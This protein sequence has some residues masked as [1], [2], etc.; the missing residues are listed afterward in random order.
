MIFIV[1]VAFCLLLGAL[2]QMS[3]VYFSGVDSSVI[4][5]TNLHPQHLRWL[6]FL[7]QL[8]TFLL[9]ALIFAWMVF[10]KRMW[11]FWGFQHTVQPGW[12]L[13]SVLM[14]FLLLPIIQYSYQLNQVIPLPEWMTAL[15]N[16][17]NN[18]LEAIL[19][20]QSINVLVI[21]ILL[22]ALLPALGEELIFRGIIQQFGYRFFKNPVSSVWIT[23]FIFSAIH[24]QFEGFIPRFILGLFL[25]Y[26]FYWT[27]N[28]L[29]P[30]IAHFFNNGLMLVASFFHPEMIADLEDTPMPDLP[31]Y[32]VIISIVILLPLVFY[33]RQLNPKEPIAE[34]ID[35]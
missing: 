15:E 24:F 8:F 31:W 33:F 27:K 21:N 19:G 34:E 9:P 23:A 22:V 30:I 16:D 5:A 13:A 17:A 11:S 32:S 29:I 4:L 26:L 28:L 35:V 25:G 12:I 18:T 20:T 10:K 14:L 3:Y 1:V 6:L 2:L 7:S